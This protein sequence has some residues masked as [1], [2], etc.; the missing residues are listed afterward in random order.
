M[1]P[2]EVPHSVI[3]GVAWPAVP[4]DVAARLLALQHQLEESQWWPPDVMLDHQFRQ[5]GRLLDHAFRNLA[6]YRERLAAA[7]YRPG[8]EI[9]P[10]LWRRLPI[11]TRRE[12]RDAGEALVSRTL[13]PA[14]GG[15]FPDATSGSTGI[16]LKIQKSELF[17]LL[18]HAFTLREEL[19]HRRDWRLKLAVIR[20]GLG[21][22]AAGSRGGHHENWG[23][24]VAEVYPTG[25]QA[26]LDI[27]TSVADQAEWLVREKP[28]YLLTMPSNL[29]ELARHF[30]KHGLTLPALCGIR[31][32][33]EV[34][35][36]ELRQACRDA[37]G[38]GIADMYSTV[39]AGYCALQCPEHEH[40]HVQSESAL[41]EVLDK[42]GDPCRP[43][44]RGRVVVTSLHNFAMPLI[45]YDTGDFAE[46]GGPCSCGRG[47]PVLD[48]IVGRVREMLVM[49]SG[50]KSFPRLRTKKLADIAGV[51]QFQVVQ[52]SIRDLEVRLVVA[53]SFASAE[54]DRLR[55]MLQTNLGR[56]FVITF[57]YCEEIP[58]SPS[59]KFFDF[60]S[61]VAE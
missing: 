50:A 34:V 25:P 56:H 15:R 51:V 21:T 3:E 20:P 14:H 13:P 32:L 9:A 46:P 17:L 45:R 54:E 42:A 30:R 53:P 60:V 49:P 38:A 52:K 26:L 22:S 4:G 41:V 6:F 61:E 24:P 12:V 43:G 19:W 2:L 27:T 48:R 16:P 18:W 35:D 44:E 7:G 47:L 37:W 29:R 31:T 28:G 5:L 8:Q 33:G 23:P 40:Y 36:G 1:S 11:L 55:E 10:E 39:E 57:A 59:G 58:R